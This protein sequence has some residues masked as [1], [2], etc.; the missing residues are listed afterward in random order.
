MGGRLSR[1]APALRALSWV[2]DPPDR[3]R[4][5]RYRRWTLQPP[6]G[7]ENQPADMEWTEQMELPPPDLGE[8]VG[9]PA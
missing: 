8:D 6:G 9:G 7:Q 3:A 4:T 1:A 5:P 2:V